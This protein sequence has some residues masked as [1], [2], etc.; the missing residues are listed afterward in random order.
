MPIVGQFGSLAGFGVFPGGALESIATVTVGSGGASSLTF[1]DIPSGFQH[2]QVR[3]IARDGLN[4]TTSAMQLR[5][6]GSS[7]NA[8]YFTHRLYGDGSTATADH[9]TGLSGSGGILLSR[10]AGST[11]TANIFGAIIL[12]ILDYSVTTKNKT[13]RSFGGADANG[14]GLVHVE[15]GLFLQTSAITQVR[16]APFSGNFAQHTT[17]ALYGVKAP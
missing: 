2:L 16:L 14:S 11:A 6:N 15:S 10:I 5:L 17:A 3:V 1:S 9:V 8:D 13:I 4:A 12:D 7:T